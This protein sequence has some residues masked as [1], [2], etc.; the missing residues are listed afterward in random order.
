MAVVKVRGVVVR[1][2]KAGTGD[3]EPLNELAMD[4]GDGAD[5]FEDKWGLLGT[6]WN[7]N[8][9]KYFLFGDC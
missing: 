2:I 4:V 3:G 9:I 7:N 1:G 5:E 8:I 6:T